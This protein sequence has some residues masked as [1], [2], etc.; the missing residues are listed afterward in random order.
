MTTPSGC[1]ERADPKAQGFAALT[2]P[3]QVRRPAGFTAAVRLSSPPA[4]RPLLGVPSPSSR[5]RPR[6]GAP[7]AAPLLRR[8]REDAP[9]VRQPAGARRPAAAAASGLVGVAG[10][11]AAAASLPSRSPFSSRLPGG[12]TREGAGAHLWLLAGR[13]RL[14]PPPEPA[15][16]GGRRP[17]RR[18]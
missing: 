3:T 18:G 9:A 10:R 2:T 12:G 17:P 15:L 4:P 5:A 16:A 6:S 1:E 8:R 14:S 7:P 13:R 11:R